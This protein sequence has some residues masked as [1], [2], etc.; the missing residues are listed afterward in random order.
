MQRELPNTNWYLQSMIELINQ[1]N[2][3]WTAGVNDRF[4]NATL[5]DAGKCT[6]SIFVVFAPAQFLCI[7]SPAT[8]C[9][10]FAVRL[11]GVKLTGEA[12]TRARAKLG[13]APTHLGLALPAQVCADARS[14]SSALH[15]HDS[16]CT[17]QRRRE[18]APVR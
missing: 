15:L 18:L 13:A 5:A 2:V 10:H 14:L 12:N 9:C 1:K 8:A 6:S 4:L 16:C 17:V 3:G 11:L 7:A